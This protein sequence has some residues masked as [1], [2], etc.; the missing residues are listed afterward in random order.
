MPAVRDCIGEIYQLNASPPVDPLT[1]VALGAA[2]QAAILKGA[3][4][5]TVLLDVTPFSL[6][7]KAWVGADKFEFS[8]LIPCHTVIPTRRSETYTT[9]KD[10]QTIVVID[11]YQGESPDP[12]HNFKIG[13]FRLEG[14]PPAKAG[15][16][17][18][19]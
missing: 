9:V 2:I 19:M 1:A 13:E 18:S 12:N 15:V 17:R 6:G 11:V 14:L 7:I 3:A 8:K 4:F 5:N 10:N 16:P